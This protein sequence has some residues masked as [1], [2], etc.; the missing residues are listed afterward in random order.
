MPALDP[1][2]NPRSMAPG[3][4]CN[5]PLQNLWLRPKLGRA[6]V[7]G[8]E[9]FDG[10]GGIRLDPRFA[11]RKPFWEARRDADRDIGGPGMAVFA[12]ARTIVPQAA[13]QL[14]WMREFRLTWN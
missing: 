14:S 10:G 13:A 2:Q 7:A 4:L 6:R 12:R 3:Q 1:G 5:E 9:T 11:L 8:T